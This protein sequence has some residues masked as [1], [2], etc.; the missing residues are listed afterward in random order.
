MRRPVS[1][2][3]I[4]ARDP[5]TMLAL[6]TFV[7]LRRA[8]NTM[9]SLLTP[10]LHKEHGLTESQFGVLEALWHLGPM[11]Q[12][13]LCEK[14]LVSGSNL[15][16]V[17]DNLEKRGLVVRG[18]NPD[19]RRAYLVKLT[20]K[21]E[22]LIAKAFGPHASRIARLLGALTQAEQRQLGSL[23]RKLGLAHQG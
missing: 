5:A 1:I 7:K 10:A 11:P 12:A 9:D 16:T 15:T 18:A 14:L 19:D 2:Q 21:G 4:P 13:R 6:V 20:A 22:A 8:V 17:V 23:C 3:R